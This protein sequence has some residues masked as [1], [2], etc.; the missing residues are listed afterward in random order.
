MFLGD[1]ANV[2][3]NAGDDQSTRVS[4]IVRALSLLY[5]LTL[6]FGNQR[7]R[8]ILVLIAVLLI[9][10]LTAGVAV[11]SVG[12]VYLWFENI[13]LLFKLIFV[14]VCWGVLRRYFNTPEEKNRLFRLFE[15]II[16]I[17]A[18]AIIAG[19]LF[20]V[21]I[22]SSY[23]QNYRFGYKGLIPAQNE[24]SG[25]FLIA[26]CYYLWKVIAHRAGIIQL[27]IV[28]FA[29]LL[30][31]TKVAL[32]FPI[33]LAFYGINWSR[34][35]LKK[36]IFRIL[37]ASFMILL[38]MAFVY[39]D[40]ILER[41]SPTIKYFNYQLSAGNNPTQFSLFMSGRDVLIKKLFQEGD[42][43]IS[44]F[45]YLIGG[46]NLTIS[47]TETDALDVFLFTGSVGLVLFYI[48]YL[49]LLLSPRNKKYYIHQLIFAFT[50]LGVSTLA[51]HLVFSAINSMYLAVL[52]FAYASGR[53]DI[54]SGST[55][56]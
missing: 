43:E 21:E 1:A 17:Q 31:G 39:K 33:L 22:L 3:L 49:K 24:V 9:A 14:F 53:T 42:Q 30:T 26:V 44:S 4:I 12:S 28:I 29:G 54:P 46:H 36:R 55:H 41:V 11:T 35:F 52:L 37:G 7:G 15:T 10:L 6:L 16:M 50:W 19:F 45:Y 25:L 18:L 8:T 51:G 27:L 38:I 23:G 56:V 20:R 40:K 47:S 34:R 2:F 48:P 13:N 32:I 5:F